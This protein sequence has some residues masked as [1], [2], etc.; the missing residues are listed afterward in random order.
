M[1]TFIPALP[2]A[3][4]EKQKL[5]KC[6][7]DGVSVLLVRDDAG[8]I[9]AFENNCSHADKPLERG[10]WNSSTREL[11]C[12]F[13]KAVFDVGQG[14]TVKVGPAVVALAVYPV[15]IRIHQG[16][17]TVFVGMNLED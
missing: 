10:V 2:T 1:L 17:E 9:F 16:V 7:V 15:E 3:H 4:I 13:H 6:N 5:S 14:G 11:L 8:T 12:P